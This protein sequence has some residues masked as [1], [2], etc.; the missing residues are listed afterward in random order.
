MQTRQLGQSGL[1]VT[2]MGLGLAA[3]GRPGYINLGHAADLDETYEVAAMESHAHEVLDAAWAA[4]I[5][6]YDA[7]RSYGRAEQ[8]L[9]S[10]LTARGIAPSDVTVG[11]KWGYTYTAG[12]KVD[13][14]VHE[15]KEHSLAVLRRQRQE[16]DEMLGE[17]LDL[18]QIHSATLKSGVLENDEVLDE[19]ARLRDGGLAIGLSVSGAKQAEVIER[20]IAVQRGGEMLFATVQA[21][22]N[23]LERSAG[24]A[25]QQ[26]HEAG[27]GVIIKEAVAN[28]RLTARNDM[29]VFAEQ[30]ALLDAAAAEMDTTIDALA[31]AGVLARPWVSIVLSGAARVDHLQSNVRALELTWSDD[32]EA[33]LSTLTETADDYWSLRSNLAWN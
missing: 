11:S 17:Q 15:V 1:T 26:A 10:W 5:R 8:F 29:P 22:W 13:A 14:K 27:M 18:Y 32:L 3:L 7:A 31:L 19:L 9:G 23:L 20:A 6:Y 2:P 16:S 21:T 28:G 24:D 12:W 30:R 33:Q 4:G 25:L